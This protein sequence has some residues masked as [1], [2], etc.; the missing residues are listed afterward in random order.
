MFDPSLIWNGLVDAFEWGEDERLKE[1]ISQL[2]A[3]PRLASKLLNEMLSSSDA[4]ERSAAIFAL[5]RLGGTRN[6]RRLEEQLAVEETREDYD[7][8]AVIEVITEALG[9]IKEV[10]SRATLVRRFR[11]LLSGTPEETDVNDLC[12]ALWRKRHPELIPVVRSALERFPAR[13]FPALDALLCLLETPPEKLVPW[14]LDPRVPANDK[15]NVLTILDEEVPREY[16]P[17]ITAL[18]CA[19]DALGDAPVA[20]PGEASGYCERLFTTLLLHS[21][22]LLPALPETAQLTLL[23]LARRCVASSDLNCAARAVWTLG[24]V[25]G[26]ED[27]PLILAHRSPDPERDKD[28]DRTVQRLRSRFA[29]SFS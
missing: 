1:L 9:H 15:M 12:Y 8:S 22:W 28:Y 23:T 4:S 18:I 5:G 16:V 14:A 11:R 3:Q 13:F 26:L 25:G 24:E 19:A 27:V 21:E 6:L 17:V 20:H 7:G 10:G 29:S 2:A